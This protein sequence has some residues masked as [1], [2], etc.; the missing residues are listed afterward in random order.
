MSEK[1][2]ILI[3]RA[4]VNHVKVF[5]SEGNGYENYWNFPLKGDDEPVILQEFYTYSNFIIVNSH[6]SILVCDADTKKTLLDYKFNSE[7]NCNTVFSLDRSQ[8]YINYKEGSKDYLAAVDLKN[9]TI[10]V[11]ELPYTIL[12][13]VLQIR[14]DGCLLF[15][16]VDLVYVNGKKLY[17]HFYHVFDR[18]TKV[19][20]KFELPDAPHHDFEIFFPVI[21]Y[22]SNSAVYPSYGDVVIKNNNKGETFFDFSVIFLDLNTFNVRN[23]ISVRDFTK[24]QLGVSDYY[25]EEIAEQLNSVQ[26]NEDYYEAIM[27]FYENLTTIK[28]TENGLWLCWRGGILR[29]INENGILSPLLVTSLLPNSSMNGMFNHACFHSELYFINNDVIILREHNDYYKS[30]MPEFSSLNTDTPIALEFTSISLDELYALKYSKE[31]INEIEE[32][33]YIVIHVEDL[34]TNEGFTQ[35]L[36]KIVNVVSDLKSAGIGSILKFI[37]KDTKGQKIQEPEF[38][39]GAVNHDPEL[40][41]SIVETFIKNPGAK[42]L[43]RNEEETALCYAVFELAKQCDQYL[44]TVLQY[45][46]VIDLDHDVFNRENVLPLLQERYSTEE[47]TK[48]MKAVS[49]D[50][51]EWYDYY[52]EG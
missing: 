27:E 48:K 11:I 18:N 39:A 32:Q 28:V 15:Y 26:K 23:I 3:E 5:K 1:Y 37:M 47:I 43:Y 2:K 52:C 10:D 19:I 31:Q 49:E 9:F 6:G 34:S 14:Q 33:D 44:A 25:C 8:L 13:K 7:Y 40:I 22:I 29:K 21:D 24:D 41:Q 38:F 17:K 42:Y 16:E 30:I 45:L 36:D 4:G 12:V 51:A 50:L 35:A 46:D 20:T